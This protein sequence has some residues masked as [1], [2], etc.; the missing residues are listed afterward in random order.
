MVIRIIPPR[1]CALLDNF[2]PNFFPIINPP[3]QIKKVTIA[4]IREATRAM[5]QLYS[6]IVKPTDNASIEVSIH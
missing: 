6:A 3:M 2:V 1:I 5:I 4:M